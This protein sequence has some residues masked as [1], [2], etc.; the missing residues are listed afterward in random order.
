MKVYEEH[1]NNNILINCYKYD[2]IYF[3]NNYDYEKD[4][5]SK[6]RI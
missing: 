1:M 6:I 3:I 5:P 2:N 4:T